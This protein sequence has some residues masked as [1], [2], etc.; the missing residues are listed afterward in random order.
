MNKS[1]I[2]VLVPTLFQRERYL[3]GCLQ[4]IRTAGNSF[5]LLMGPKDNLALDRVSGLYDLYL[6]EP[7][8]GGLASKL[9]RGLSHFP[10]DIKFI[11]WLGDDDVMEPGALDSLLTHLEKDSDI[12]LAFGSCN[13]IDVDGGLIGRNRSGRYAIPLGKVGPFL[14]PQPGSVFRRDIFERLGGLDED[15][16][17]AFDFDMF[18]SMRKFGKVSFINRTLAN[19]RWHPDSLTVSQR[20]LSAREASKVRAK[21]AG[22]GLRTLVRVLNPIIERLTIWAGERIS[23]R[24]TSPRI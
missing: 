6:P 14:A 3:A 23:R 11:T 1:K 10:R 4:S 13:Y 19:F 15:F 20:H 5:I 2:G 17:F 16:N 7:E 8:T 22:S 21:H 18:M 24:L 12:A 9:N